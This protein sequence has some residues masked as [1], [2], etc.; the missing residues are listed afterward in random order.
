M[1]LLKTEL[2]EQPIN[3][4]YDRIDY[5]VRSQVDGQVYWPVYNQVFL[6]VS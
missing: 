6:A 5:R 4:A 2:W 1:K 3:Y